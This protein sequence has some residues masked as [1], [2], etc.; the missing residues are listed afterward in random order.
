MIIDATR[1]FAWRNTFPGVSVTSRDLEAQM[2]AKY[3]DA[4]FD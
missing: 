1:P 4:F 2:R 3:G